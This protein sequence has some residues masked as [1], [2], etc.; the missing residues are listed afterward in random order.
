MEMLLEI[1]ANKIKKLAENGVSREELESQFDDILK[2]SYQEMLDFYARLGLNYS[3]KVKV[4]E[5]LLNDLISA[6]AGD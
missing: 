3:L 6:Y 2:D 4:K 5:K 1:T